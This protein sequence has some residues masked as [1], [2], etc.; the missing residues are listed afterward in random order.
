[1]LESTMARARQGLVLAA[2][3]CTLMQV[4]SGAQTDP[5]VPVKPAWPPKGAKQRFD[6]TRDVWISSYSGEQ[7]GS[8]G[9]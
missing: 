6:V 4:A 9:G 2:A 3:A 5:T 7:K 8:N 1:M